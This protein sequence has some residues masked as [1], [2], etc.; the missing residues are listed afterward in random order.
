M[1]RKFTLMEHFVFLALP[2][3]RLGCAKIELFLLLTMYV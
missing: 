2:E 1:H 3:N